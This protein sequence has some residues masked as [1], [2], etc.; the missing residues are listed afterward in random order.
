VDGDFIPDLPSTLFKTG[1]FAKVPMIIGWNEDDGSLFTPPTISTQ[2]DLIKFLLKLVPGL[3][4]PTVDRILHL[5]PTSDFQGFPDVNL[6]AQWTR[7]SRITRDIEFLCPA[8]FVAIQV[9]NHQSH[10]TAAHLFAPSTGSQQL[11]EDFHAE[12]GPVFLYHLNQT[13]FNPVLDAQGLTFL[14]ISHTA[15][16]AYIFDE[17]A[18]FDDSASNVRLA[19]QISG[20]WARFAT[21]GV[22]SGKGA[23]VGGW[24]TGFGSREK[25]T[26]ENARVMVIGRGE[27]GISMLE[28]NE[29]LKR[30]R[31]VER[32]GFLMSDEVIGEIGT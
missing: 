26:L 1:R 17:V 2:D 4:K 20:S 11:L 21:F 8:L 29:T 27:P 19:K 14:G 9:N 31:L 6:T 3:S 12:S 23:S 7:A 25:G 16:I 30:E 22:P 10:H 28:G 24:E 5:Y 32:C 13:A 15:D 18:R